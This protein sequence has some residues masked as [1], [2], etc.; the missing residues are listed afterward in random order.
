MNVTIP[1]EPTPER[2]R[3]EKLLSLNFTD[4]A[5]NGGLALSFVE[6]T[7][8]KF[9]SSTHHYISRE[10]GLVL[11]D[12]LIE[13]YPAASVDLTKVKRGDTVHVR[14]KAVVLDTDGDPSRCIHIDPD[15]IPM[16]PLNSAIVGHTPAPPVYQP[17]LLNKPAKRRNSDEIVGTVLLVHGVQAVIARAGTGAMTVWD[18]NQ[19]E[20]A[21]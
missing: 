8:C 13:A 2:L 7:R 19:L 16:W 14:V 18:S 3:L 12:A 9:T 6:E 11:R 4:R 20:G 5:N 17:L 21:Q 10:D 1:F 15:S